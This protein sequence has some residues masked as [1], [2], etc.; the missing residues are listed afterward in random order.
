M[1]DP[2]LLDHIPVGDL[3]LVGC[4]VVPRSFFV[5]ATSEHTRPS[6]KDAVIHVCL[7]PETKI[8]QIDEQ[9]YHPNTRQMFPDVVIVEEGIHPQDV[10]TGLR[11]WM[12]HRISRREESKLEQRISC[13]KHLLIHDERE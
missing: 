7:E 10:A 2:Q 11:A 5:K 1:L 3:L 12:R 13:W 6:L 4:I 8:S 9:T